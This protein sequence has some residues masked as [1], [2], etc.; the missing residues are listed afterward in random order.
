VLAAIGCPDTA[1][2]SS[3]RN[4]Y[5]KRIKKLGVDTTAF[6]NGYSV[7]EA[8]LVN[9]DSI[10]EQSDEDI[11]L[12]I[13]GKDRAYILDRFNVWI[14]DVPLFGIRG[15]NIK[16][17]NSNSFDTTFM[18]ALSQGKNQIETSVTDVNGTE[19]YR[20]PLF[21]T[22]TPG[23]PQ[24]EKLHFIGIGI[25][26]FADNN[27][28]LQWSVKDIRDLSLKLKEKYKNDIEIDTLFNENVT[29]EKVKALKKKL[30]NSSINDRVIIA[31]SGH[32][33]LSRD[34]DYYLSTYNINFDHPEQSGLPYDDLDDLLDSIPARKKLMLIDACHSGEVD[35]EEMEQYR[36]VE[37]KLDSTGIQKGVIL[38]NKDSSKIGM[39]GSVE[40]MKELFAD[41]G[42]S[43]GAT[44]ISAAAGTQ[45]SL[46]NNNLKNGVFTYSILEYMQQHDHA[47]VNELK[48]YVDQRVPELTAGMQ[49]PTTR[50]E[51]NELNWSIW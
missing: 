49:V 31:Y 42:K 26:H 25:N 8:D 37:N 7:P 47:T 19:S 24:K 32:G 35:K 5:Y 45:F 33:L 22:Y 11:K 27:H 6:R 50:N 3:Y 18:I 12:H 17:R 21:V 4:I 15:I 44:I 9:R 20:I 46:E 41:V 43:T 34:Y 16:S 23:Q 38:I 51:N 14:N 2:I 28:D 30:E 48:Q 13:H 40:L 36:Q 29:V 10:K 39:K 1:L